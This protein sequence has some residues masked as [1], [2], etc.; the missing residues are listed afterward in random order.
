MSNYKFIRAYRLF[1]DLPDQDPIKLET[2]DDNDS[3]LNLVI[4]MQ[5]SDS[6]GLN[7]ANIEVFNLNKRHR[8]AIQ[9]GETDEVSIPIR[10][11][12]GYKGNIGTLF[13]G[14]IKKARS[15]RSDSTFATKIEAIEGNDDRNVFVSSSNRSANALIDDVVDKMPNTERGL[16]EDLTSTKRPVVGASNPLQV[17]KKIASDKIVWIRKGAVNICRPE[18]PINN[19]I[20]LVS[21]KTG[22]LNTPVKSAGQITFSTRIDPQIDVGKK[23]KLESYFYPDINGEYFVRTIT[24]DGEYYGNNW[25]QEITVTGGRDADV[26]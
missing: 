8:D 11:D 10:L 6:G 19:T 18:T 14:S 21:P 4:S 3:N 9:K 23:I 16:I 1:I 12:A 7:K 2:N 17:I 22:L 15:I 20:P 26:N 25:D 24:Y 5:V 13:F